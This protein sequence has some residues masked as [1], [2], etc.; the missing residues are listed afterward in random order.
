MYFFSF[1]LGKSEFKSSNSRTYTN[2][3]NEPG[4]LTRINRNKLLIGVHEAEIWFTNFRNDIDHNMDLF[5]QQESAEVYQHEVQPQIELNEISVHN[6][7]K[8][9]D[10]LTGNTEFN[11]NS[12]SK[13]KRE[14][15]QN[16]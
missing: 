3:I 10:F 6:S 5:A 8:A 2:I 7:L 11:V 14:K 12:C 13:S 4:L 9:F 16:M 15:L 1:I